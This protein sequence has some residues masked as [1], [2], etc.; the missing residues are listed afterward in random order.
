LPLS[1]PIIN[2]LVN[3]DYERARRKAWLN[4]VATLFTHRK[5]DLLSFDE[6][7]RLVGSSNQ[8]YRGMQTAPI[9][10]I[11]GSVDRYADFDREFLP[12]QTS[13][14][15]RW[16]SI[17]RAYYQDVVLPPVTLYKVGDVF[18]VKDGNHRVSVAHQKGVKFI[19]A[20]VIEVRS[21]VPITK[22]TDARE[23]LL[24]AEYGRFLEQTNLDQLR[25]VQQIIFSSLGRYDVLLEHIRVH[26]YFYSIDHPGETLTWEQAVQSWYDTLY[27]P[28]VSTIRENNILTDFPGKTEADLYLWVM[29]HRY[30]LAEQGQQVSPEQATEDYDEK[31]GRSH[32]G[33]KALLAL[34]AAMRRGVSHVFEISGRLIMR[35]LNSGRPTAEEPLQPLI[36]SPDEIERQ[37]QRSRTAMYANWLAASAGVTPFPSRSDSGEEERPDY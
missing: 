28:V 12:A 17:D 26:R 24:L 1:T 19:D 25:P 23:L 33:L 32:E 4:E 3:Q 35:A 34:P 31:Y 37:V 30:S 11:I 27:M 16:T 2:T 21:K 15:Q 13:T 14:R 29:D 5:N 6:V 36:L 22:D 18:F 8:S 20:E 9:E 10:Q 7:A